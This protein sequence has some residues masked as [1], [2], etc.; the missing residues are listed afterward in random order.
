VRAQFE[1]NGPSG[2][3]TLVARK[4]LPLPD[5]A[6][7]DYLSSNP[8]TNDETIVVFTNSL[9]VAL[10]GGH[11][12]LSVANLTLGPVSYAI[13]ATEWP[14]GTQPP[15]ITN[16][17]ISSNSFC[18]TWTSQPGVA[19]HVDGLTNLN[20][21][22]WVTI[23]PTITATNFST[24][25]CLALPSPFHF[26]RVVEGPAVTPIVPPPA[27]TGLTRQTNGILLN[28]TGSASK[29]YQLDWSPQLAPPA[30]TNFSNIFT[31]IT[32]QFSFL[33]DGSQT[34]GLGA[35]RFYRVVQLP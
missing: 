24:T 33:D 1:V 11:W 12:Y 3:V 34:S 13:K 4:G 23:S 2:D 8:G 14:A 20:S 6:M 29:Q 18:L 22:T 30:W 16:V 35:Q 27:F 7:S 15:A 9:P 26:F 31:S 21:T 19:Y 32:G 5:L 10:S 17:S 25:W 28:W